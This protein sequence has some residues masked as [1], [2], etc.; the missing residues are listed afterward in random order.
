MVAG[1]SRA[2]FRGA[3]RARHDDTGAGD[4]SSD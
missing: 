2:E 4:L 3:D 1:F